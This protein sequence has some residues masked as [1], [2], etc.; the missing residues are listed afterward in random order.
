MLK[1]H[2]SLSHKFGS[3]AWLVRASREKQPVSDEQRGTRGL[4]EGEVVFYVSFL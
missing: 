2:S 3:D 1:G 4:A